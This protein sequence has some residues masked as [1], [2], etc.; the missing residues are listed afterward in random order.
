[1]SITD[2]Q[3]VQFRDLHHGCLSPK[4]EL[5]SCDYYEHFKV[6]GVQE[7]YDE[8]YSDYWNEAHE[9]VDWEAR[10]WDDKDGYYHP[11]WHR[12]E[13]G[14]DTR[15]RAYMQ[16]YKQGWVRLTYHK[17]DSVLYAESTK[18]TL[19]KHEKDLE[20]IANCLNLSLDLMVQT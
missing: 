4:G 3:L 15:N 14:D 18:S 20:F 5:L 1:M 17:Q 2:A 12:F 6:M 11:E 10:E 8:I 19:N 7:Y 13:I 16:A 9:Q